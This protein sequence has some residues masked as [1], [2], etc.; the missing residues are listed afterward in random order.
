VG[1]PGAAGFN[2]VGGGIAT[3]GTAII[4]NTIITDNTASTN[5]NDV[6]GTLTM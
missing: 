2:G 4:D 3:F 1:A 5:D 6:D